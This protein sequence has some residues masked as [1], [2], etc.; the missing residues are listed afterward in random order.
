M[1][2]KTITLQAGEAFPRR[3]TTVK[4]SAPRMRKERHLFQEESVFCNP[5]LTSSISIGGGFLPV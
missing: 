1:T 5:T 2:S 4:E 3:D